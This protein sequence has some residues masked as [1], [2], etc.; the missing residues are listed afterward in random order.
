MLASTGVVGEFIEET[1][2]IG[3]SSD[4]CSYHRAVTGATLRGLMPEPAFLIG[5]TSPCSGGL[6]VLENL[7]S[8]FGKKMFVL[9]IPQ[10]ESS[11]NIRYLASQMQVMVDFITRVTGAS[12]DTEKLKTAVEKTNRMRDLMV[13]VYDMAMQVPSPIT[14]KELSNFGIVMALFL[15]TDSGVSLA[16]IYR[17]ELKH[18][19]QDQ[20][21]NGNKEKFRL[22]WVQ[23]RIQFKNPIEKLLENEYGAKIVVDELNDITWEP[24]DADN[25][26]EGLA[27]RCISIPFN[28][29]IKSRV[30][31]LQQLASD[32]QIDG[33]IN[34]CN[35]GC[36]QGAGA[37][38]LIEKGFKEIGIPVLNLEV[39]CVDPRKFTEGQL[40]TRIEAFLELLE[41][42]N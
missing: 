29:P 8:H 17:D 5:T 15:G 4:S 40:K 33:A 9:H 30:R 27:R 21:M 38:G 39:D 28:G 13:Q 41:G 35:W 3:Y 7:S 14:S 25:I 24:I 22:L 36:R 37:R 34:P 16:K 1:E 19:V 42:H 32:Y 26:Y 10:D 2:K 23:N 12:L 6:A 18:R 31:H 11:E 20:V